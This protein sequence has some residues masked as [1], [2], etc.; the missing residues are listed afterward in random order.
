MLGLTQISR[1]PKSAS[2]L[3]SSIEKLEAF[4]I[5]IWGIGVERAEAH[6]T[7]SNCGYRRA[8]F[9]KRTCLEGCHFLEM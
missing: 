1:V 4:C 2:E 8:I 9:A 7:E 5:G 6:E 3:D